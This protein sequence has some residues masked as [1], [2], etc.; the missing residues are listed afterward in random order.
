MNVVAIKPAVDLFD[1]F[2]KEYPKKI[3]K[4]VCRELWNHIVNGGL[5][6]KTLCR[7]SNSY[8]K[9]TLKATPEEIIAGAKR[10][11]AKMRDRTTFKLKD[12]GRFVC[13]PATWLNQGRWSDE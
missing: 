1:E 5:E 10:Y 11:D 7:D 8:V 12:D 13:Q 2:W 9:I 6:T 4:A 3:G